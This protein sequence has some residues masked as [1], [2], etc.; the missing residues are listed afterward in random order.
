[1][2]NEPIKTAHLTDEYLRRKADQHWDMAGLARKDHDPKDAARH[3][4]SAQALEAVLR[5]RR[6]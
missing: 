6:L 1:M 5:E 3:T 4:K 2:A